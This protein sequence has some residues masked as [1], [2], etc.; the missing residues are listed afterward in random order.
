MGKGILS[1]GPS[2]QDYWLEEL[3]RHSPGAGG[4]GSELA[5]SSGVRGST[6]GRGTDGVADSYRLL[7]EGSLK[8]LELD[9]VYPSPCPRDHVS[10]LPLCTVLEWT[11]P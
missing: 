3:H 6:G 8:V 10:L 7:G 2:L 1:P 9:H 11:L 4:P 5:Y